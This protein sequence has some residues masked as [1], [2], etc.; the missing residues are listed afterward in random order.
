MPH[1]TAVSEWIV[2]KEAKLGTYQGTFWLKED[3]TQG[4]IQ[5]RVAPTQQGDRSAGIQAQ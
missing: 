4:G 5:V 3:A 1:G 2:P